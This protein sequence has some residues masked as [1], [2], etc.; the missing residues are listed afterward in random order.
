MED[1]D[2]ATKKMGRIKLED[3][4]PNGAPADSDRG[5]SIATPDQNDGSQSPAASLDGIKSRSESADTPSSNKPPQLSRKASRKSAPQEPKLCTDLPDVT[6]DACKAFQV[7]PDCLYGSKHLGSTD[8][9]SFDC[10]CR[11][12]WRTYPDLSFSRASC[13]MR[14][15][16]EGY[17][18]D[19]NADRISQ[20][21]A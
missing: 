17:H 15:P 19:A 5:A 13:V 18:A 7:I 9:D 16:K 1:D 8:N 20:K 11:E 21:M 14:R 10:E 6:Q 12:D 2:Y 3:G 4:G